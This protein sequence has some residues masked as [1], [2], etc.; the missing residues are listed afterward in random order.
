MRLVLTT[1]ELSPCHEN[2]HGN[3]YGGTLQPF[4]KDFY[5]KQQ[6]NHFVAMFSETHLFWQ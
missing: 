3:C 2:D 5:Q 4:E 6:K 1:L